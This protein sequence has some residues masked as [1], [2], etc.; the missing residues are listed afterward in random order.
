MDMMKLI[1]RHSEHV[2]KSDSKW[3]VLVCPQGDIEVESELVFKLAAHALQVKISELLYIMTWFNFFLSVLCIKCTCFT[4][5]VLQESKGDYTRCVVPPHLFTTKFTNF[6][7]CLYFQALKSLS[8]VKCWD[9]TQ[10]FYPGLYEG[11]AG[12]LCTL[13]FI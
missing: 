9:K 7:N 4:Y 10:S 13:I 2:F 3:I 1:L 5:F 11:T 6:E 8:T 12:G